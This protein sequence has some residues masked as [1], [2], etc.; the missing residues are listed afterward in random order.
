MSNSTNSEPKFSTQVEDPNKVSN[1]QS[2][3]L[4]AVPCQRYP[5]QMTFK[6]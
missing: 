3:V 2:A 6:C 4:S 1:L 5:L